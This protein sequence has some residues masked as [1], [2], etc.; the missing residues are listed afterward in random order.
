MAFAR[1]GRGKMSHLGRDQRRRPAIDKF[2]KKE[3]RRDEEKG[4]GLL[5]PPT[6]QSAFT[7]CHEGS[8][9][10]SLKNPPAQ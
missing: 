5:N 8:S 1:E 7:W 3:G 9:V 6:G 4:G 2:R 10:Q